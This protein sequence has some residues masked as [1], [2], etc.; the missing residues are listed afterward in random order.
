MK[1]NRL[2]YFII[3]HL[4]NFVKLIIVLFDKK[5]YNIYIIK[6]VETIMVIIVNDANKVFISE[7]VKPYLNMKA[8]MA[9]DIGLDYMLV[10]L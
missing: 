8:M 7:D 5:V 10:G 1:I 9:F 3:I 4:S 2:F 6:F